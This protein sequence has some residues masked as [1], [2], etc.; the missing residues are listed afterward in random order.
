ME[1]P[2]I[3]KI[4]T[5]N[6]PQDK[7]QVEKCYNTDPRWVKVTVPYA[8]SAILFV[9][10]TLRVVC[11]ADACADACPP[12]IARITGSPATPAVVLQGEALY[13]QQWNTDAKPECQTIA[14]TPD[15]TTVAGVE[16]ADFDDFCAAITDLVADCDCNCD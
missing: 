16:Y 8:Q 6:C 1:N 7:A 4:D 3:T 10:G 2:A 9:K 5:C 13:E 14:L 15:A 11:N 12:Q